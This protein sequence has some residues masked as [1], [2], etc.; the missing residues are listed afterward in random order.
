MNCFKC[1]LCSVSFRGNTP[2]EIL[3][4][5]AAAGLKYIEWGSDVHAPYTD[6]ER[7]KA[8]SELQRQ[9]G[10]AC[11]SYGTYFRIG[12]T[13]MAE[14]PG[15]ISA[16]RILGTDLLRLW[17]GVKGSADLDTE[18]KKALFDCCR[19][20]AK[21]AEENG[22]TLAMECHMGTY[23]DTAES[24]AELMEEVDSPHFRMYWQPNQYRTAEE[25]ITHVRMTGKYVT[26]VHAFNWVGDKRYPL[27]DAVS[28]WREYLSC[29]DGKHTVLLEFL[30]DGRLES[31]AT[32]AEALR[33]I[34]D[35]RK[36]QQ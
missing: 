31:L 24:I 6:T 19:T 3:T 22:V 23:T 36:E 29:I 26:T 30:H 5:M 2:E 1:G 32:E 12:H 15:Y 11:S 14:L 20:A 18:E 34:T 10:I 28:Q 13:D 25:N 17:C 27:A 9:H 7:L 4:A 8:I 35:E 21:I 33:T 16:A